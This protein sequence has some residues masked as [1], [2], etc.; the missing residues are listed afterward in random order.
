MN[1]YSRLVDPSSLTSVGVTLKFISG[2]LGSWTGK[3]SGIFGDSS[4]FSILG[5]PVI[6]FLNNDLKPITKLLF[7]IGSILS[8]ILLS[9]SSNL[10]S[11][12]IPSI[13]L[14]FSTPVS[15]LVLSTSVSS[16]TLL[17]SLL[18][19]IRVILTPTTIPIDTIINSIP[20]NVNPLLLYMYLLSLIYIYI[21]Y[22][23]YHTYYLFDICLLWIS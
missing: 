22:I 3:L 7:I 13:S 10:K 23:V 17:S 2:K 21:T 16:S 19:F 5:L 20:I 4:L 14:S 1:L 11:S 6:L 18:V 15:L 8:T 12:S 9:T